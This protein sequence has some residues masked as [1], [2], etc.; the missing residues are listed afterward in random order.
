[1]NNECIQLSIYLD[2]RILITLLLEYMSTNQSLFTNTFRK[3]IY[4]KTGF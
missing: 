4:L 2:M 3:L 1:M